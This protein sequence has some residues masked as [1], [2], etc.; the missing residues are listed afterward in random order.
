MPYADPE[1]QIAYQ[2]R[3]N[4]LRSQRE[5]LRLMELI[6]GPKC[7]VCGATANLEFHHKDPATKSF[8]IGSALR[9]SREVRTAEALKCEVRCPE[10]HQEVHAADHGS[11]AK[12]RGGCRCAL[13]VEAKRIYNRDW[14]A[15][16]RADGR[17]K[18]R[19]NYSGRA[20]GC[21]DAL[22]ATDAG[23]VTP[24]VHQD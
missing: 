18:S 22:Q 23:S 17:D 9:F 7:S 24:S 4:R 5:R 11:E 12:F 6:G 15:R 2:I 20:E 21:T 10:H 1:K 16:W 13:C 3:H 19:S 8:T 14:M